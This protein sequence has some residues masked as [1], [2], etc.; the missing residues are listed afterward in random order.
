MHNT[1]FLCRSPSIGCPTVFLTTSF[2]AGSMFIPPKWTAQIQVRHRNWSWSRWTCLCLSYRSREQKLCWICGVCGRGAFSRADNVCRCL[3][4]LTDLF[5]PMLECQ[6]LSGLN[7][8]GRFKNLHFGP[9]MSSDDSRNWFLACCTWKTRSEKIAGPQI[10]KSVEQV[11][12]VVDPNFESRQFRI[13]V[14]PK[15]CVCEKQILLSVVDREVKTR[16]QWQTLV[17]RQFWSD[18]RGPSIVIAEP[19]T[20]NHSA[21]AEVSIDVSFRSLYGTRGLWIVRL[22]GIIWWEQAQ[23]SGRSSITPDIPLQMW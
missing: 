11:T 21:L 6:P 9:W 8:R 19:L 15:C 7:L 13:L 2:R 3:L 10:S 23:E 18:G 14:F 16:H 20:T 12:I 17:P 5:C 4:F 1:Y 22:L